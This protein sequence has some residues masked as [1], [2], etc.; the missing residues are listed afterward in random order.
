MTKMAGLPQLLTVAAKKGGIDAVKGLVKAFGGRRMSIPKK[1][2]DNHPL[3]VAGGRPAA[4]AIMRIWGGIQVEFPKGKRALT[5]L[6]V[7]EM[8]GATSNEIAAALGVC[9]RQGQRV[10]TQG[11]RGPTKAQLRRAAAD[12]R[13]IDIEDF[14]KRA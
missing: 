5:R 2:G 10:K 7:E 8:P 6:V 11:P 1:A 9:Y 3:V 12:A 4:D 13:Q 14:I